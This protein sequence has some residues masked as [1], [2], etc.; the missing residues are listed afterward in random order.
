[1]TRPAVLGSGRVKCLCSKL[2][3]ILLGLVWS[4]PHYKLQHMNGWMQEWQEWLT[5]VAITSYSVMDDWWLTNQKG[6]VSSSFVKEIQVPRAMT[7]RLMETITLTFVKVFS[8][9]GRRED[10]TT[11]LACCNDRVNEGVALSEE[12]PAIAEYGVH[13]LS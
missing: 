11:T 1:M 5:L 3:G 2:T 10:P 9:T 7:L 8:L 12:W 13:L 4:P 6:P